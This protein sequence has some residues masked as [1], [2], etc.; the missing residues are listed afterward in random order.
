MVMRCA[1]RSR[2]SP[3]RSASVIFRRNAPHRPFR[4]IPAGA[5]DDIQTGLY[6]PINT[7]GRRLVCVALC[8]GREWFL[9][10]GDRGRYLRPDAVRQRPGPSPIT[11][12]AAQP[13]KATA[14][15]PSSAWQH[16]VGRRGTPMVTA[17][18][19]MLHG[20]T[21][22][23]ARAAYGGC[24]APVDLMSP[25]RS[26]GVI[27]A[28]DMPQQTGAVHVVQRARLDDIPNGAAYPS[29]VGDAQPSRRGHERRHG[30]LW[31]FPTAHRMPGHIAWRLCMA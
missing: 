4:W 30:R 29:E 16:E 31:R 10:I 26:H 7:R 17:P 25:S 18:W 5:L 21:K 8:T 15:W 2:S 3:S 12:G 13:F 9:G 19:T 20:S 27:C 23:P 1:R 14:P 24:A 6:I 28:G 22:L 11:T